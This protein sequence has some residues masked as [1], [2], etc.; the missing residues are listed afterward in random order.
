MRLRFDRRLDFKE[1]SL[2]ILLLLMDSETDL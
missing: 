1:I 2:L